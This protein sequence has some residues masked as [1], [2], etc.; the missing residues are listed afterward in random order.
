[1]A[2]GLISALK[3]NA[4]AEDNTPAELNGKILELHREGKFKEAIPLAEKAV[5]LTKRAKGDE[6]AETAT[7]LNNLVELYRA[8]DDYTKHVRAQRAHP[9]FHRTA[10][11]TSPHGG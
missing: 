4:S 7:S 8:T 1:L 9:I 6:D 5:V 2:L 10:I 11:C 3:A